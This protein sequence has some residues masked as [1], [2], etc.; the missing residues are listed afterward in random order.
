MNMRR[1]ECFMA[2]AECLNFTAAAKRVFI[3]QSALSQQIAALEDELGTKLFDRT[4]HSVRMTIAG[5]ILYTESRAIFSQIDEA[6]QKVRL[7]NSGSLGSLKIGFLAMVVIPFLPQVAAAFLRRHPRIDL[8]LLPLYQG[9]IQ[10]DLINGKLDLAFTRPHGLPDPGFVC[11]T[12]YADTLAVAMRHDHPLASHDRINFSLLA[13]EPFI[14]YPKDVSPHLLDR[15]LR[16]CAKAGFTPNIVKQSNRIESLLF[17][18]EAGAGIGIL[19]RRIE[20]IH[21]NKNVR[22][23]DIDSD[24]DISNDL[25]LSWKSSNVNP[26]ISFFVNEFTTFI[27]QFQFD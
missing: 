8:N 9:K 3:G 4:K 27:R 20:K 23:V 22:F 6:I 24:E 7:A 5:E 11:Q 10:E 25:V 13:S 15:I 2:V 18:I 17:L 12:V 26:A 19:N 21:L 1:L 14:T 16:L